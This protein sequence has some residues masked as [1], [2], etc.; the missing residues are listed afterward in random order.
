MAQVINNTVVA[1]FTVDRITK[2]TVRFNETVPEDED[3]AVGSLYVKQ[4]VLTEAG[5]NV[6]DENLVISL[7]LTVASIPATV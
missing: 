5:V 4:T 1:D 3:A 2:N 7:T 6:E